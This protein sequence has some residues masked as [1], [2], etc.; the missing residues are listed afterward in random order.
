MDYVIPSE[1]TAAEQMIESK[2]KQKGKILVIGA[3]VLDRII[4]VDDLPKKGE[5]V[6]GSKMVELPGGKGANQ[7]LAAAKLGADVHF[8]TAVGADAIADKVLEPLSVAGVDLSS[9]IRVEGQETAQA[10]IAVDGRGENQIV[11]CPGAYHSI[12]GESLEELESEFEWADWVVIQNELDRS[13]LDKGCELA[14]KHFCKLMINPAPFKVHQT[15]LPRDIDILVPNEVEARG[16]LTVDDYLSI[17]PHERGDAWKL[18]EAVQIIVTLGNRGG[19]WFDDNGDRHV[20][21]PHSVNALDTVGAGDAFCGALVAF[22]SEGV[23]IKYAIAW[24]HMAAS[25]STLKKGAQEGFTTREE[26]LNT[27]SVVSKEE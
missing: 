18:L 27:I 16:L 2:P 13:V 23:D 8:I 19:E 7:A 3:S 4:Y 1:R 25:L 20:Y 17:P 12:K 21:L 22:L 24:A 6:I 5:T 15:P 14:T 10:M 26:L 9:V 11:A